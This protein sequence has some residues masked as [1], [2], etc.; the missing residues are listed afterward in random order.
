MD[1]TNGIIYLFR[2]DSYTNPI[3]INVGTNLSPINYQ[4]K[5][6]DSLYFGLMEP[7]QSFEEAV[8]K[9]KYTYLNDTDSKGNT[10]LKIEPKDT[11]NLKVGKYYYM[12]KLR[13]ID[14]FGQECVKTIVPPTQFFLEGNNP[15]PKGTER[16]EVDKYDI[17]H[18]VIE[19][20]EVED[21][22]IIYEGGE[23]I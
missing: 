8:L 19:G 21:D 7:N 4:L 16:Y 14:A 9:K 22:H 12:I 3:I 20:G 23:I 2:G 15:E 17:D 11:L 6:G 10:L 18:L 5:Q 1:Y 13:T